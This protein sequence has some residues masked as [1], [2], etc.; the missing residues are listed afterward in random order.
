[1][2]LMKPHVIV[3]EIFETIITYRAKAQI[4]AVEL[5]HSCMLYAIIANVVQNRHGLRRH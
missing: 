4:I 1:M 3:M 5:V 2:A